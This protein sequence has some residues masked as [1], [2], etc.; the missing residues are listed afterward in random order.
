MK[1]L[2]LSVLVTV[3]VGCSEVVPG[4]C[5]QNPAGGTGDTNPPPIG[6]GVGATSGDFPAAPPKTPQDATNPPPDC[7][8]VPGS[9]CEEKC[10][11]D[12]KAAAGTCGNIENQEQ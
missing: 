12:Y 3:I 9:P 4:T 1:Y 7:Y 2:W 8:S 10:L 5:Y 11:D 6:A